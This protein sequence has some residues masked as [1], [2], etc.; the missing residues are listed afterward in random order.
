M[1]DR[2]GR[3]NCPHNVDRSTSARRIAITTARVAAGGQNLNRPKA[4][5][6]RV[7]ADTIRRGTRTKVLPQAA[8]RSGVV[9]GQ[10]RPPVK[11]LAYPRRSAG[12]RPAGHPTEDRSALD[13]GRDEARLL[14]SV[15]WLRTMYR[16]ARA[17]STSMTNVVERRRAFSQVL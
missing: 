5:A 9:R 10:S 11:G 13:P 17:A 4:L 7:L 15:S 1:V 16:P 6:H 8:V 12:C 3:Q 2:R 14:E